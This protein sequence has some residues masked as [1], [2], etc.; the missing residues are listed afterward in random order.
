MI[1]KSFC[2]YQL[3]LH[4]L[5]LALGPGLRLQRLLHPVEGALVGL[6]KNQIFAGRTFPRFLQKKCHILLPDCLVLVLL[7]PDPPLHLLADLT[8]L[9]LRAEDL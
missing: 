2:S 1:T 4:P 6:P 5:R 7:L 3:L 8:E 9:K